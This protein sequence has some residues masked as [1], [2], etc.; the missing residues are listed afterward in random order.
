M[1]CDQFPYY[2]IAE[3]MKTVLFGFDKYINSFFAQVRLKCIKRTQRVNNMAYASVYHTIGINLSTSGSNH[4]LTFW[5]SHTDGSYQIS[6]FSKISQDQY[7]FI[8]LGR[9]RD[10]KKMLIPQENPIYELSSR[11]WVQATHNMFFVAI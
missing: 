4:S 10:E 11:A 2:S 9:S 3:M 7:I 5:N 1:Q 8:K 6:P